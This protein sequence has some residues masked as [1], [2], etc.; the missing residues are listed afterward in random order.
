MTDSADQIRIFSGSA[1]RELAQA[2]CRY[3][4]TSL[5]PAE[6]GKFNDGMYLFSLVAPINRIAALDSCR[7]DA[8]LRDIPFFQNFFSDVKSTDMVFFR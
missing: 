4:G 3:L 1:N 2:I 7:S 6:I 8:Q 5:A